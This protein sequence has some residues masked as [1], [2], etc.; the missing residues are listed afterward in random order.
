MQQ[1]EVRAQTRTCSSNR[2]K[3]HLH[4]ENMHFGRHRYET[5]MHKQLGICQL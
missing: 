3:D 4:Y 2:T 1:P 5:K